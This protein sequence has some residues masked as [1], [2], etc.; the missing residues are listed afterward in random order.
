LQRRLAHGMAA[1]EACAFRSK[2]GSRCV[3]GP[4]LHVNTAV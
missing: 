2:R 4:T 3:S 1:S